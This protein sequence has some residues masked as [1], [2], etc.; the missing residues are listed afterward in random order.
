MKQETSPAGRG[1]PL[2]YSV[3][4]ACRIS[5]LGRTSIFK[6]I[7]DGRLRVRRI[8]SRTLILADSLRELI[9]GAGAAGSQ[10]ANHG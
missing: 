5:S 7:K 4:D 6:L 1:Q 3:T 8:G 9:E 10:D 2:A